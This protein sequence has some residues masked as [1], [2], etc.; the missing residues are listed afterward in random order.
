MAVRRWLESQSFEYFR[1]ITSARY[2]DCAGTCLARETASAPRDRL[3]DGLDYL[4][5][6][7]G[8]PLQRG[9]FAAL[10]FAVAALSQCP[11]V[12]TH[13][14][15]TAAAVYSAAEA[16]YVSGA[17]E[18]DLDL[19][20]IDLAVQLARLAVRTQADPNA[21]LQFLLRNQRKLSRLTLHDYGVEHGTDV[22]A[23]FEKR[24]LRLEADAA[25]SSAEADFARYGTLAP[26][27][28][29]IPVRFRSSDVIATLTDFAQAVRTA[30]GLSVDARMSEPATPASGIATTL[31]Y[32]ERVLA[33]ELRIV[34]WEIFTRDLLSERQQYKNRDSLQFQPLGARAK[35]AGLPTAEWLEEYATSSWRTQFRYYA[36]DAA[37]LPLPRPI[38]DDGDKLATR[39]AAN[40]VAQVATFAFVLDKVHHFYP[41]AHSDLSE[42]LSVRD[43]IPSESVGVADEDDDAT[44]ERSTNV[45]SKQGLPL[46]IIDD[47]EISFFTLLWILRAARRLSSTDEVAVDSRIP[48]PT[49]EAGSPIAFAWRSGEWTF[50]EFLVASGLR[51]K[52]A[53]D[54]RTF[55][56]TRRWRSLVNWLRRRV[57]VSPEALPVKRLSDDE[58]RALRKALLTF[59]ASKELAAFVRS[60]HALADELSS[61]E[62]RNVVELLMKALSG[63]LNVSAPRDANDLDMVLVRSCRLGFLPVEFFFRSYQPHEMHLLILGLDHQNDP[64]RPNHLRPVSLAFATVVGGLPSIGE[65]GLVPAKKTTPIRS[66]ASRRD[67]LDSKERAF[68]GSPPTGDGEEWLAPYWTLF[69]SISSMLSGSRIQANTAATAVFEM[70]EMFNHEIAKLGSK[71]LFDFVR[72]IQ[73]LLQ[74]SE[75][76]A[77]AS[78][79]S[80]AL[81]FTGEDYDWIASWRIITVPRLWDDLFLSWAIWSAKDALGEF[82]VF[83]GATLRFALAKIFEV[84]AGLTWTRLRLSEL[85][86]RDLPAAKSAEERR[87]EAIECSNSPAGDTTTMNDDGYRVSVLC[88]YRNGAE[89]AI[90]RDRRSPLAPEASAAVLEARNAVARALTSWTCNMFYH[91]RSAARAGNV[92]DV[93][94]SVVV[95]LS[96]GQ[97]IIRGSNPRT[98]SNEEEKG[99]SFGTFGVLASCLHPLNGRYAPPKPGSAGDTWTDSISIP[100]TTRSGIEWLIG[101][102]AL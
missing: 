91:S 51:S 70:R 44:N 1:R 29:S 31:G 55:I 64:D 23:P 53:D 33:P 42:M 66:T 75:L 4:V 76:G 30:H 15:A 92:K 60:P 63:L 28:L 5:A 86:S 81:D 2:L 65:I 73:Q 80:T 36:T 17:L 21:Y 50:D 87:A 89:R 72:P 69:T 49:F 47:G 95:E 102:S 83:D 78:D 57:N 71:F 16:A 13:V 79:E 35:V 12:M 7:D 96:G 93:Q 97:L 10:T 19:C 90:L 20:L 22:F 61:E 62:A 9:R 18:P 58:A 67:S 82:Y 52:S 14:A 34:Q 77:A 99:S 3:V 27:A 6:I 94:A 39:H 56:F 48:R 37:A 101:G 24:W 88:T 45:H 11:E 54:S 100:V 26:V 43:L 98:V 85:S 41:Q 46:W 74:V 8:G 59:F 84:C 38:N 25:T 40:A 32:L 68:P